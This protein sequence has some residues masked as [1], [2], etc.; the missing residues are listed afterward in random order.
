MSNLE[1]IIDAEKLMKAIIAQPQKLEKN[2]DN[3]I[4]RVLQTFARSAKEEAP[5]ADSILVNSIG[6]ER[7]GKLG[8]TAGPSVNYGQAVEEGTG[9]FGPEG[10]ASHSLPP[11]DN[12]RDW[13]KRVSLTPRDPT[14]DEDDLAWAIAKTIA[15]E[16]TQPQPYLEPAFENNKAE[17]ERLIDAAINASLA[18]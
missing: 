3:A 7:Q 2:L 14:M 16:G 1:L 12:I 9:I 13:V 10:V 18:A 15:A 8:G 17:A 6:V 4:G 11:I 5:K